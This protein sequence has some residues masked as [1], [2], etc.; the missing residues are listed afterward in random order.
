[1]RIDDLAVPLKRPENFVG[2]HFFN[3]VPLMPLVEVIKGAKTSDAAASTIVGYGVAMGKTPI[4]VKDG[5]GF[6]V[7]RILTPYMLAASRLIADGADFVKIDQVMEDFGWPMGPCYLN[8]VIGMDTGEHVFKI[9]SA[10]FPE[11]MQVT[12][13]DAIG[14][15]VANKRY[16]QKNGVGFYSYENDPT[17]KPKK[18]VAADTHALL[19]TTQ[20]NGSRE[21]TAQEIIDR[22][23]LPLIIEAAHAFEDGMVDTVV[24]LD[25]ALLLGLGYPQYLGGALKYAD[26]LGLDKVVA[27]SDKYAALGPMYKATAKMR[28]MAANKASYYSV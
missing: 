27:L 12:W 23:M 21:F 15:M 10:G 25:M 28:D 14:L 18:S 19:A 1:L 16:G 6:L 24:E 9:I 13:K 22:M 7:N 3:P 11:R 20:T 26:W 17:G 8:D 5:P 4:V 2:M